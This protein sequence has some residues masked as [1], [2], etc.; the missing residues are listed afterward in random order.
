MKSHKAR[1]VLFIV[2][3]FLAWMTAANAALIIK[4]D[5]FELD[6]SDVS[7]PADRN[8]EIVIRQCEELDCDTTRLSVNPETTYHL[9]FD[10]ASTT[11]DAIKQAAAARDQPIYIFY[12]PESETVTR[13]VLS[14]RK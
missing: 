5:A 9:G 1:W 4:E 11:L 10:S 13:I 7:L 6:I 8:G 12:R 3:A 14:R 2:P